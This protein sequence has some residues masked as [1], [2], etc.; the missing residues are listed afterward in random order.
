MGSSPLARGLRGRS[1]TGRRASTDHPRS[2]GVYASRRPGRGTTAGSSPLA[3]GLLEQ[4]HIPVDAR[5]IIPAR[6]GFTTGGSPGSPG[7]PDHPRSRGVYRRYPSTDLLWAGSSP[8][9]RGLPPLPV[10]GPAVGGII[11]ARAGFTPVG[12]VADLAGE[13]HPR[14]RGVYAPVIDADRR[15]QGS[16]PL[17]RGLRRLIRDENGTVRIIPARAGFTLA[18]TP[19]MDAERIIPARAGF[20]LLRRQLAHAARDHPRSR[21]VYG[22]KE[23]EQWRLTGSSPLARGLRHPG[24]ERVQPPGIIPARAGFTSPRSWRMSSSAGSSPLARGLR[25]LGAGFIVRRRIIPAR[26]G[27]TGRRGGPL[28]QDE[29]HPRS[30]GVY[31]GGGCE[32]GR[33][34]GSSP[35]ARGLLRPGRHGR[36]H[37]RIIPA[38]AG[39]TFPGRPRRRAAPDHPRSRGVYPAGPSGGAHWRGSS[40]LARGLQSNG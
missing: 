7:R 32:Y 15:E 12:V 39:F 25:G 26:A 5:R 11:P 3:R 13:D 29:D 4:R 8:L 16:S 28:A 18:G 1:R 20:T 6:A 38:R 30:R 36:L 9:A 22:R 2:R 31:L 23:R 27:F 10:H 19:G 35:L 21:G 17:A 14:S 40:P 34:E 37:S 33:T 24:P